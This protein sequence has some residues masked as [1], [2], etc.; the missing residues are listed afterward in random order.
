MP[1]TAREILDTML[2]YLGFVCDIKE[3]DTPN[4]LVLQIYTPER[5]RLIG[6][7]GETLEDIQFLLN[8]LVQVRDREAPRVHVDVEHFREMREDGLVQKVRQFGELVRKTGRPCHLDPMNAY[9]R[10]IVHNVFKDDPEVM[11]WSPPD[12]ARIKRIT[13]QKR[14]PSPPAA[15]A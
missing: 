13:L 11:S 6:R 8:R 1:Q 15:N 5:E 3:F 2:G 7:H 14:N 12:D 9:D 10:R 4:G